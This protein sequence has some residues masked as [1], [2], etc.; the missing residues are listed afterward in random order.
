MKTSTKVAIFCAIGWLILSI[1]PVLIGPS[2]KEEF[3]A[4][5]PEQIEDTMGLFTIL[6]GLGIT[7]LFIAVV[8]I[9]I[10]TFKSIK[11]HDASM[12]G[13]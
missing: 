13:K 10:T 1:L 5:S 4:L 2:T 7:L 6:R 3:A 12:K 9:G 11:E 8:S